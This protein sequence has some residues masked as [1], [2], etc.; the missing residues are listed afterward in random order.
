MKLPIIVKNTSYL[1]FD[2]PCYY[3]DRLGRFFKIYDTGYVA[4]STNSIFNHFIDIDNPNEYLI[5]EI[6]DLLESGKPISE[7][8]FNKQFTITV[9]HISILCS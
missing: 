8:D 9:N 1:E 7:Q 5:K 2:T 6:R 4:V 3:E